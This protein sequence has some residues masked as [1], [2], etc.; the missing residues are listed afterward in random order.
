MGHFNIKKKNPTK[1]TSAEHSHI[2][3]NVQIL[4]TNLLAWNWTELG[5]CAAN[6]S[7]LSNSPIPEC[8]NSFLNEVHW[9]G[10]WFCQ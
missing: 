7:Y 3:M 9:Y 2:H 10:S 6:Y 5:V 8:I 1:K 4:Y